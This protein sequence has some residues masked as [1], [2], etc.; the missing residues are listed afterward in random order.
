MTLKPALALLL[1]S[2]AA[3]VS[4]PVETVA[5]VAGAPAP[6][7][8]ADEDARLNAFLDQAF[9]EQLA[10]SPQEQTGLGRKTNYN[11]LDDYTDAGA[12][13]AQALAEAQLERL[14]HQFDL[15]RLS[16]QAQ[17]S[18]RLFEYNVEQ[19]R[20]GQ[21]WRS[22]RFPVTNTS[23]PFGSLPVF[24]IN[25]HRVDSVADAEAYVARLREIE[26]VMGE[27]AGR[28]D[29]QAK[30]GIVPPRFVFEPVRA[31]ALR[32]ISG[33]PFDDGGA[34][35]SL[36]ADF[37]KKVEALDAP[38]DVK[39]R[40]MTDASAALTGPANAAMRGCLPPSPRCSQ[41]RK[42]MTAPGASP[43]AR[44]STMTRCFS[45]R[46]PPS[47]PRRCTASAL[48]RSSASTARC[49]RSWSASATRAPS[50]NSL[51]S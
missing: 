23:S 45:R 25:Q 47:A 21:K 20:L 12:A 4:A 40:L 51:P 42:P 22:H 49:A 48:P 36:F 41:R 39:A 13:K 28:V 6:A 17:V 30:A 27:V 35:S 18:Y 34:D 7:A 2:T 8:A 46:Q 9:E 32:V 33:A 24:L 5:P 15:S 29:A 38:A 19:G 44:L 1:L 31:D 37:K 16:P 10:L 11:R 26:R 3:C 43:T 50:S 14:K